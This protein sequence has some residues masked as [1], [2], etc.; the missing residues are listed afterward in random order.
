MDLRKSLIESNGCS[1]QAEI[2]ADYSDVVYTFQLDCFVDQNG[3]LQFSVNEPSSIAGISGC[4]SGD[5]A[6]LTFDDKVLAFPSLADGEI[7]PVLAPWIFVKSLQSGYLAGCSEYD[8]GLQIFIDDCYDASPL[9]LEIFTD[10]NLNPSK[11]E[12]VW[13]N[14]RI[15]SI[16]IRNFTIL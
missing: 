9:R 14:R 1:F 5:L 2:I 8:S 7:T 15:L 16:N 4:I 3:M 13:Q 12:I 6:T 11:T 10:S